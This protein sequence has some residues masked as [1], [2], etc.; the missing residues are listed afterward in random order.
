MLRAAGGEVRVFV[1]SSEDEQLVGQ[2]TSLVT[3]RLDG[4]LNRE[5]AE[6][7]A[8]RLEEFDLQR[9]IDSLKKELERL[10]PIEDPSYPERF[11]ELAKLEGARR[12]VREQAERSSLPG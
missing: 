1:E 7:V 8:L 2:L 11:G 6:H 4:E 12:R 5:Y 10:N 9:R 3:E